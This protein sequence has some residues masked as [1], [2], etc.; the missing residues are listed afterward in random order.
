SPLHILRGYAQRVDPSRLPGSVLF[1]HTDTS[2]TVFDAFP[3]SYF[4]LLV[5]PRPRRPFEIEDMDNLRTL[6]KKD[7][8]A[9]K[10][11]LLD[12]G[13]AAQRARERIKDEM[14]KRF[15]FKWD[16]WTGF[17][18]G[19]SM[20]HLHLHVI[21]ADLRGDSMKNKKHYNSFHPKLGFFIHFD[22]VMSWF[23]AEPSFYKQKS[24]LR[25][26][27]YL[28]LLKEPLQC[29]Y[30]YEEIKNMPLLKEHLKAEFTTMK[31][32]ERAKLEKK[33]QVQEAMA[34]KKRN[35]E[36]RSPDAET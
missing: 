23:D 18:A 24:A 16:I 13:E 25:P 15:G 4:H 28:D 22:E 27:A 31:E 33:R 1:A 32:R 34:K 2:L 26:Q 35:K 6:L 30:C 17:H 29:F 20:A 8:E 19:P 11:V 7:K 10:L 5:L 9:A 36:A 14:L 3:K 12:L 21:S